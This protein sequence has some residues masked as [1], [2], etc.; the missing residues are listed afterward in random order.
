MGGPALALQF[1]EEL[2]ED[3]TESYESFVKVN[4]SKNLFKSMRTPAV[5]VCFIVVNYACQEFL[6]LFGLDAIASIFSLMLTLV[7]IALGTWTYSRYS[8]YVRSGAPKEDKMVVQY[9][10]VAVDATDAQAPF[11][12]GPAAGEVVLPVTA[13]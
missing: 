6:Q 3:I 7:I 8:G 12:A 9:A 10:E 2:E 1:L 11:K 13:Q 5:L 4:N